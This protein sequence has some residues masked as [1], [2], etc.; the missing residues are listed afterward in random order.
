M[1]KQFLYDMGNLKS[2]NVEKKLVI[3]KCLTAY[4][5]S[6]VVFP[7]FEKELDSTGQHLLKP[8]TDNASPPKKLVLANNTKFLKFKLHHGE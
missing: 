3:T 8:R 6:T 7:V 2:S 1:G 5:K 4:W